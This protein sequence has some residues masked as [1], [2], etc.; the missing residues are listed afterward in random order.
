M[1]SRRQQCRLG[2]IFSIA[3]VAV[4][5]AV[6][7]ASAAQADDGR[8][9][10][11]V[12]T[13]NVDA[14][15]DFL[16]L[17]AG[18]DLGVA[19]QQTYEE[20][21]ATDFRGRAARLA[22][23]IAIEQ[24]DLVAL[25]EVALWETTAGGGRHVIADQLQLL[26]D[27]LRATGRHYTVVATNDLSDWSVPLGETAALRYL[28]RDVIL[29]RADCVEETLELSNVMVEKYA[30]RITLFGFEQLNGW[31]SVDAKA[32]AGTVRF[33][34]TH[35]EGPVSADDATQVLQGQELIERMNASPFPVIAVGDFNSDA[36]GAGL[37]PDQTPTA[38]M[39]AGEGYVDVWQ[40][41][42]P[43]Q[44][45]FTWP[46][47]YEDLWPGRDYFPGPERIDL[48]FAKGLQP[49]TIRRVGTSAPF[50]SDHAGVVAMLLLLEK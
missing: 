5:I 32:G 45:G 24:P 38:G 49:L 50:P 29:A 2:K 47:Y 1:N 22:K 14:G 7:A 3:F 44:E 10:L 12:M 18:D 19:I 39:I 31:M 6:F 35:L 30:S 11:K 21:T 41:L 16:Y 36:S 43:N 34:A 9:V 27:A 28:D 26:L 46:L 8:R 17:L 40:A 23:Q 48:V 25:E 42:R 37:G 15:T 4:L 13:Y 20:V 33:F